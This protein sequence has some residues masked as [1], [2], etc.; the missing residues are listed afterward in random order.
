M[1][2]NRNIIEIPKGSTSAAR[3]IDKLHVSEN[4]LIKSSG[5]KIREL[6]IQQTS[7]FTGRDNF[8]CELRGSDCEVGKII[9][10]GNARDDRDKETW[11]NT[12]ASG[13]LVTGDYNT[14]G[15]S[16]NERIHIPYLSTG[17]NN[18]L[19]HLYAELVS[20]DG[21]NLCNHGNEI[22]M[23]D[24]VSMISTFHYKDYHPDVGMMYHRDGL[25]LRDC[26]AYNV[27]YHRTGHRWED[28]E[29]QGFLSDHKTLNCG[30]YN[31]KLYG[32]HPEHGCSWA[33]ATNC[34][35]MNLESNGLVNFDRKATIKIAQSARENSYV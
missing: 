19:A 9:I 32:V 15:K 28:D 13:L 25:I 27:N 10:L 6:I 26:N 16:V 8:L 20:G 24:F 4:T 22:Y 23:A 1:S 12:V 34:T 11:N 18:K 2:I 17:M 35:T 30:I 31:F 21:F 7:D 29:R 33:D 14:I 5:L 3:V